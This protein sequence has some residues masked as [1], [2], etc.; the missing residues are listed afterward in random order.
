MMRISKGI[1]FKQ[2]IITTN[3]LRR[4]M[5]LSSN[6]KVVR[7]KKGSSGVH[8]YKTSQ[9]TKRSFPENLK[10]V[11]CPHLQ[12]KSGDNDEKKFPW[13]G[14][15]LLLYLMFDIETLH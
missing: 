14:N 1:E 2:Y 5:F 7:G 3:I 8:I 9:V 15:G 4:Y 10:L 12:D 11:S 13:K 6:E